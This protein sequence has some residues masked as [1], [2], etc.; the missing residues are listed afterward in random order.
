MFSLSATKDYFMVYNV[1]MNS[2]AP[3][4]II[5]EDEQLIAVYKKRDVL[6][7]QTEDKKTFHHNLFYYL[8]TYLGKKNEKCYL[9]QRLDFETSGV[10]V[11]AKTSEIQ[12]ILKKEFENRTVTRLYEAVVKEEIASSFSATVKMNIDDSSHNVIES[13]EGKEAITS[14]SYGNKIQ[15]GTALKIEIFTGRRNQIRLAI[16]KLGYT[17]IGDKRYAK[18][19]NKRMYL[20]AYSLTFTT[21]KSLNQ[22]HFEVKPLWLLQS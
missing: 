9:V 17:L 18:D 11:F 16:K 8:K 1:A 19:E 22:R 5:Y 2:K 21:S 12:S 20:N 7:V 3:Y 4:E 10:M 6:T 14:I 13:N 15:I